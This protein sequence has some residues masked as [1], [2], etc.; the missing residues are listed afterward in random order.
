MDE[1]WTSDPASGSIPTIYSA[2]LGQ[3]KSRGFPS[4][5]MRII[6]ALQASVRI[7]KCV[8]HADNLICQFDWTVRC[9]NRCSSACLALS[10][11]CEQAFSEVKGLLS[12]MCASQKG[13][14]PR[15]HSVIT[16]SKTAKSTFMMKK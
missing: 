11:F 8:V 12:R 4:C 3:I 5:K 6:A 7:A 14:G 1:P 9:P 2:D 13:P 10:K 15:T 16:S